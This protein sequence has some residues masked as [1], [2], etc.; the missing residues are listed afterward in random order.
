MNRIC[1]EF[2]VIEIINCDNNENKKSSFMDIK[3]KKFNI[4]NLKIIK[5][6]E[7]YIFNYL[8]ILVRNF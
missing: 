6:I 1:C 8:H 2:K 5:N 7:Y 3:K 4:F